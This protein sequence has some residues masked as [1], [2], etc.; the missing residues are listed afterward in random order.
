VLAHVSATSNPFS[1]HEGLVFGLLAAL[2]RQRQEIAAKD[3]EIARKDAEIEALRAE[4]RE[5]RA[6][7]ST[8]SRTSSKPPSSDGY[9][10]P[11]K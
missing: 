2:Q 8:N 4:L 7:Q 3:V 11:K 6:R 5:V 10:K 9:A 1:E